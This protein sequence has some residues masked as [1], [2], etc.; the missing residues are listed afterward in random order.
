MLRLPCKTRARNAQEARGAGA[1]EGGIPEVKEK[2]TERER[3]VEKR[4]RRGW[5]A[6]KKI[7][8]SL[9]Q[10]LAGHRLG[11]WREPRRRRT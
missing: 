4:R 3:E 6:G 9:G 1:N 2:K 11:L 7:L 10:R 8:E 5:W